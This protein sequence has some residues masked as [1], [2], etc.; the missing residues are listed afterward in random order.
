MC[1]RLSLEN[2]I[3]VTLPPDRPN[4][5]LSVVE[6]PKI[7]DYTKQLSEDLDPAE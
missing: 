5:I 1:S 7:E 6:L 4:L 2:P 3:V